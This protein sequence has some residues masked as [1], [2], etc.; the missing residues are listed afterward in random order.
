[1]SKTSMKKTSPRENPSSERKVPLKTPIRE[2]QQPSIIEN[3]SLKLMI[4]IR[5]ESPNPQANLYLKHQGNA[6]I[7]DKVVI[8]G[9]GVEI[10]PNP[11]STPYLVTKSARMR[12]LNS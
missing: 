4:S 12:S 11:L 1:M 10:R 6:S 2:G 7:V 3:R 9:K 5:K 8:S